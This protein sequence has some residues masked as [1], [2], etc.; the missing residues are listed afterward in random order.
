MAIAVLRQRDGDGALGGAADNINKPS[1]F[2]GLSA[3]PSSQ[4]S[5]RRL[6][7]PVLVPVRES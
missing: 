6:Y 5:L 2:L 7:A 3:S 1:F 4:E